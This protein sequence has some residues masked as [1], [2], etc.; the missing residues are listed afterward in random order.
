[1]YIFKTKLLDKKK[2]FQKSF[3]WGGELMAILLL[4]SYRLAFENCYSR[5]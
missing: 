4:T 3:F 2:T 5:L 1:M